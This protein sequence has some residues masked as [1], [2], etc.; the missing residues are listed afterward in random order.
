MVQ[1]SKTQ[2]LQK[3]AWDKLQ[4]LINELR[5]YYPE[6]GAACRHT[7][8]LTALI[9]MRV[10]SELFEEIREALICVTRL[11]S[12]LNAPIIRPPGFMTSLGSIA[13]ERSQLRFATD[14]ID[15]QA[16]RPDVLTLRKSIFDSSD[17]GDPTDGVGKTIGNAPEPMLRFDQDSQNFFFSD[18]MISISTGQC[19]VVLRCLI[20][21]FGRLVVHKELNSVLVDRDVSAARKADRE[22][23]DAVARIKASFKRNEIPMT[24]SSRRK[25]GYVLHRCN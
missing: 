20:E 5:Q 19:S 16:V 9:D 1:V 7:G 13:E 18:R 22:V 4:D 15:I 24:I 12:A 23:L 2:D 17:S 10:H 6:Y 3:K 8:E 21:N 11:R 25:R 14:M